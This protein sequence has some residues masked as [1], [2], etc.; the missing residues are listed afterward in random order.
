MLAEDGHGLQDVKAQGFGFRGLC[1]SMFLDGGVTWR[2]M[3]LS[4]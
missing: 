1:V 2:N 3:G 4:K